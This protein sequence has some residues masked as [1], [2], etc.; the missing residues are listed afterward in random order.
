VLELSAF[1]FPSSASNLRGLQEFIQLHEAERLPHLQS[2]KIQTGCGWSPDF[3]RFAIGERFIGDA[4]PP[5]R[6]HMP[7]AGSFLAALTAKG[8]ASEELGLCLAVR[9]QGVIAE[10]IWAA[11]YGAPLLRPVGLRSGCLSVWGASGSGKSA[12]QAAATAAWGHPS[13]LKVNGDS[14]EAG[15]KGELS[16]RPDLPLWFDE[17]QLTREE[18]AERLA[19]TVGAERAGSKANTDG[20]LREAATWGG[21]LVL[22]SGEKS[23]L[24]VGG[25]AGARNR[26]LEVRGQPIRDPGLAART[27]RGLE[28]HHGHGGPLFVEHLI[29]TFMRPGK[30]H[31][32]RDMHRRAVDRLSPKG[33]HAQYVGLLVLANH[34]ARRFVAGEADETAERRSLEFGRAF[35]AE[36]AGALKEA[37]TAVDTAYDNV[38]A[39]VSAHESFFA[40]RDSLDHSPRRGVFIPKSEETE[41]KNVVA[42]YPQTV[43]EIAKLHGFNW[44]QVFADMVETGRAQREADHLTKK[45]PRALITDRPRLYWIVLPDEGD[46]QPERPQ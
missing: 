37:S 9:D 27:H 2:I 4:D 43:T 3:R 29:Q 30:L 34:L 33:E 12:T 5:S 45:A 26:T 1:G 23:L 46:R 17:T 22:V 19:Y 41:G 8:S 42:L 16:R 7:G 11:G 18:S 28:H 39:F 13:A 15:L 31:E 44:R 20:S 6:L 35:Y 36:V 40:R 38:L 32:L 25:A 24:Q 10:A 21:N 14:S